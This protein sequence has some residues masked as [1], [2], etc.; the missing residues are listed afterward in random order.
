MFFQHVKRFLSSFRY[1]S[2]FKVLCGLR[3]GDSLIIITRCALIVKHFFELFFQ[4][5]FRQPPRRPGTARRGNSL[6]LPP[7][8]PECKPFFAVFHA[9]A[10]LTNFRPILPPAGDHSARTPGCAGG[11]SKFLFR[12]K[13]APALK[14]YSYFRSFYVSFTFFLQ[15]HFGKIP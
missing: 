3:F 6:I 15:R 14:F 13:T 10:L 11:F 7:L 1:C 12:H 5:S 2:I 9:F 4:T 8:P